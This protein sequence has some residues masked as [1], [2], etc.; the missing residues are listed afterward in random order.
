[1]LNF[2][3]SLIRAVNNFISTEETR[4]YLRGV[5]FTRAD[6]GAIAVATDGHTLCAAHDPAAYCERDMILQFDKPALS[7]MKS[8]RGDFDGNR[9]AFISNDRTMD[10][11]PDGEGS[12]GMKYGI[13]QI[14]E[15]DGTFPDWR[16]VLPVKSSNDDENE[17]QAPAAFD[18][19]YLAKFSKMIAEL[20]RKGAA[21]TLHQFDRNAP[22]LVKFDRADVFGVIMPRREDIDGATLP[23]WSKGAE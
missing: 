22:A 23:A 14:Q 17:K 4:Y 5:H 1:M 12:G 16:R 3:A 11:V 20:D 15:I 18:A 6:E 9:R 7:L 2:N 13:A 8:A 19:S 21:L 10:I